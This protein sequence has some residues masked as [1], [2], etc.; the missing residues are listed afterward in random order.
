MSPVKTAEPIEMQFELWTG[1][2]QRKYVLDGAQDPSFGGAIFK[3]NSMPV[4][5]LL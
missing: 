4:D 2:D 3:V 1:V 5:T